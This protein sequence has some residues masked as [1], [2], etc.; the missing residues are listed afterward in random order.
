MARRKSRKN[1]MTIGDYEEIA[2]TV[3]MKKDGAGKHWT[4]GHESTRGGR[5]TGKTTHYTH[6]HATGAV[7]GWEHDWETGES[8]KFSK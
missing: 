4:G 3:G 7:R 1:P 5:D 6:D 8:S 2:E